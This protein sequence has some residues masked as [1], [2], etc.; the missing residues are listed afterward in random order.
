MPKVASYT[1]VRDTDLR[2]PDNGDIDFTYPNFDAP[3]LSASTADADRP[4]LSFKVNPHEDDARLE[5]TLNG[6]EVFGQTYSAGPIRTITEVVASGQ[7]LASGNTL[8]VKREGTG[9]F[10]ISDVWIGY[11]ASI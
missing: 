7:V 11:K 5:V 8:T 4:I 3:N 10:T 9:S 1:V 2:L 6:T